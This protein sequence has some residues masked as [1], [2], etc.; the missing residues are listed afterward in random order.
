MLHGSLHDDFS[1][2]IL[3]AKDRQ[4]LVISTTANPKESVEQTQLKAPRY[5]E[6]VKLAMWNQDGRL[7]TFVNGEKQ[8]DFNQVEQPPIDRVEFAFDFYGANQ[9]IGLRSVRFAES[10]RAAT[11]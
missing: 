4:A 2:A 9:G 6:P 8:Q 1:V 3:P 5:E 10:T 11:G 7:R